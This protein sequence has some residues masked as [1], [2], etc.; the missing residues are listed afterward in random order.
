MKRSK[1]PVLGLVVVFIALFAGGPAGYVPLRVIST[2]VYDPFALVVDRDGTLYVGNRPPP[3][4][5]DV[6]RVSNATAGNVTV[7][8]RGSSVAKR[9]FEVDTRPQPS[10]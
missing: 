8:P 9:T 10:C 2:G 5:S 6:P 4:N 1:I 7:F 3:S